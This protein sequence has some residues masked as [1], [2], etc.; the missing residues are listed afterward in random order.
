[1]KKAIKLM[2]I[3]AL[4]CGLLPAQE[5]PA[6]A[7][8]PEDSTR[9]ATTRQD[10]A[11]RNESNWGWLGLLGLAGLA[12]LR[13]RRENRVVTEDDRNRARVGRVA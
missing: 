9:T 8:Q 3:V 2:G 11:P 13:G 6:T 7:R 10:N 4:A 5:Q 12:G 1:M